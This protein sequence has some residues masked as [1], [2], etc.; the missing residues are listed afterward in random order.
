MKKTCSLCNFNNIS[1]LIYADEFVLLY[2][3]MDVDLP[4][5]LIIAPKRHVET[6]HELTHD[7]ANALFQLTA[8]VT[9]ILET[10]Y[11]AKKI[12]HC[13]FS[14]LT[15]HLHFHLFPRY[16]GME[17]LAGVQNEKCIDGP[18]LFTYVRTHHL[19]SNDEQKSQLK[20]FAKELRNKMSR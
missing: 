20:K 15:P 19:V 9:K 2:Q 7:E 5:Y 13:C 6:Y 3:N 1:S 11:H 18:A 4:G 16:D 10:D 12:Y 8:R 14:E 17:K